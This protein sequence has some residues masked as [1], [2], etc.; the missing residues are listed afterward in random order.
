MVHV[1]VTGAVAGGTAAWEE[2]PAIIEAVTKTTPIADRNLIAPSPSRATW[3]AAFRGLTI[4]DRV[5]FA[6]VSVPGQPVARSVQRRQ[7]DRE[8]RAAR[9]ASFPAAFL[10]VV[11]QQSG[12]T[13]PLL[14]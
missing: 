1:D 7:S 12:P 3:A 10:V 14:P 11:W 5:G 2:H 13:P 9:V 8:R 6:R 4:V